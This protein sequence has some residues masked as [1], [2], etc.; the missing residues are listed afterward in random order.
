MPVE[1]SGYETKMYGLLFGY[2][3]AT[4]GV[5]LRNSWNST[6]EFCR[7][8]WLG[9]EEL[10][11]GRADM[12]DMSGPVGVVDLMAESATQAGTVIGGIENI[13]YISAFIAVNLAVMNMLPVPALDGG[14]VFCLIVTRIIETL[15][16]KRLDPKYEAYIHTAGMMLLLAF[17][18]VIMF[19]DIARIVRK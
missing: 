7:W 9:L 17:M 15:T 8:V 18:A 3:E 11:S 13:L 16:G 19:N 12:Q 1:Y 6:M 14:R 5:I 10:F 4:P 2:E